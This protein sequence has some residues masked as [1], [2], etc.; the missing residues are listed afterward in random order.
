MLKTL[1][2]LAIILLAVFGIYTLVSGFSERSKMVNKAKDLFKLCPDQ[3]KINMAS[4]CYVDNFIS[5]FGLKKTRDYILNGVVP[6]DIDL[7]FTI[8]IMA[9]C[10]SKCAK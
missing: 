7:A 3:T 4:S 8:A 1:I 5:Q 10:V 6:G 2:I 9:K